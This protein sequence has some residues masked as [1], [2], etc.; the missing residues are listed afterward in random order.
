MASLD[1]MSLFTNIPLIETINSC[2]SD[3]H[4]KNL[5]NGKLNKRDLF[6]L[7]GTATSKS[8]IIFNYL[9]YKQ[10]N[11]VTMDS[12]LG[13]TLENACLCHYEKERLNNCPILFKPMI[14][15]R[16][17]DDIFVFWF[18]S[19]KEHLHIFADYMNKQHKCLRTTILSLTD[20]KQILM[21]AI[22]RHA[23]IKKRYVPANQPLFINKKINKQI[24]KRSQLRNKLLNTKSDIYRK[25]YNQQR[26]FCVNLIRSEKKNFL[27]NIKY[28]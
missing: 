10:I 19:S 20:L 3:L 27:S 24:M 6:K 13:P 2:V 17:V 21:K 5:Y 25:A 9:C 8:S 16:Y 18:F 28:K 26:N 12:P 15:R 7:L 4:N 1:V 11:E 23:P 22:Q 14:Y